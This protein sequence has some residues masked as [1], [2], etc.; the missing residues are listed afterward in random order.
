MQKF[1]R[2]L[3]G[4]HQPRSERLTSRPRL[5][6][7]ED[8]LVPSSTTLDLTTRGASGSVGGVL[9]SQGDTGTGSLSPFLAL[10][11]HG[12]AS[13]EQGYNTDARPLQFDEERDRSETHSLKI[14]DVPVVSHNGVVYREFVLDIDQNHAQPFLSL[15]ELRLYVGTSA[16]LSGYNAS[17]HQLAGLNPLYDLD[18]GGNVTVKL[19]AHI[20]GREG[21]EVTVD[22]PDALFAGM[23]GSSYI[24]LFS[25]FGAT[26]GANGGSEEWSVHRGGT[27]AAPPPPATSSLSGSVYF[28]QNSDAKLDTGDSPIQDVVLTLTGTD[29]LGHQV[30][31]T[32][33]TDVNGSYQFT[34]LL[35]GVYTITETQP[36]GFFDGSVQAGSLGG[37]TSFNQISNITLGSG[38]NGIGNNFA[39]LAQ[40]ITGS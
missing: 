27:H 10:R 2:L 34:G 18:A 19:N 25:R 35:P 22:V 37:L 15:D 38:V 14:L 1:F 13:V 30:N 16:K 5:E 4:S 11:S 21:G 32:T 20:R 8:R 39:E 3:S 17:T 31:L 24:S 40:V 28:D 36:P 12:H 26:F 7:L 29:N 6:V 33:K 9:F 23:S